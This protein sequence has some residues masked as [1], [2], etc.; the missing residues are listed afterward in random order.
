MQTIKKNGT[1]KLIKFPLDFFWFLVVGLRLR[2]LAAAV[3]LRFRVVVVFRVAIFS[4]SIIS[5]QFS[6][7]NSQFIQNLLRQ[8]RNRSRAE[9]ND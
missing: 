3:V 7:I 6:V 5:F 8:P 9:R 4:S 2:V 1:K